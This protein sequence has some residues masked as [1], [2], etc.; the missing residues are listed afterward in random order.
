MAQ[1]INQ[2]PA[3]HLS[4]K[5]VYGQGIG[6]LVGTPTANL[7]ILSR[8]ELHEDPTGAAMYVTLE[9][10]C[11]Q[12]RTPPCTDAILAN[13]IAHVVIGS[14]DPNPKAAGG[15]EVLRR[16]GITVTEHFLQDECDAVNEVFCVTLYS[17]LWERSGRGG[18]ATYALTL[19]KTNKLLSRSFSFFNKRHLHQF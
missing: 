10:C 3:Y 11:H 8:D 7:Q 4:G 17:V 5:I 2:T 16:N 13:G 15:A 1:I 19:R 9:P 12:G 18:R 6:K 14:R